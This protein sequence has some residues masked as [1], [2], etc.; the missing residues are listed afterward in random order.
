MIY[1]NLDTAPVLAIDIETYDPNLRTLGPGVRRGDGHILG[2]AVAT[3]DREWYFPWNE[4]TRGFLF[5]MKEKDFITQNGLYDYDWLDF[6]PQGRM[7]DTMVAEALID[8]NKF[9]FGL[10]SLAKKYL[11]VSKGDDQITAYAQEKG[12]LKRGS[13]AQQFLKDMPV[14]LVGKYAMMDAR[15]TFDIY[16][17]QVEIL[18]TQDLGKIFDLETR[19]L[20]PVLQM[21]KNGVRIDEEKLEDSRVYYKRKQEE[22]ESDIRAI[23][24]YALN[25]NSGKQ[26]AEFYD[27]KGWDYG[28]TE[29]DNPSFGK[30]E[31]LKHDNPLAPLLVRYRRVEKLRNSFVEALPKFIVN[32]RIHAGINTVKSDAGGTETGRFS[33]YNPNFQQIPSRDPEAKLRLRGVFL[34]EEG[35]LWYKPDYS[36]EEPRITAHYALGPGSDEIR[37]LYNENPHFDIYRHFAEVTDYKGFTTAAPEEQDKIRKLF[38]TVVLGVNYGMGR[39]KLVKTLGLTNREGDEFLAIFHRAFPFLKQTAQT[40]STVGERRGYVR[41]IMGRRRRF[42]KREFAYK[43][44]NSVIQ[45]SAGDIMKK[46]MVDAYEAGIFKEI[47]PLITVHDELDVSAHT[48]KEKYVRDLVEIME[49]CV[50]LKVPLLVDVEKGKN[51]G[52]VEKCEV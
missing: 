51:W 37:R 50:E 6:V 9:K 43:S 17:H 22:V 42:D 27:R 8:S 39:E 48:D 2:L 23:V 24:G 45:G 18:S 21:I 47:T 5:S 26:L 19:L 1:P 11:K 41:T 20:K 46:A 32:G 16:H 44:L 34:P 4:A 10:D 15:Q 29:K 36:S 52:E 28:R 49:T 7:L 25:I 35:E 14:E 40:A 31:L 33:Y 3:Y 30:D 13:K 12:W 38:K